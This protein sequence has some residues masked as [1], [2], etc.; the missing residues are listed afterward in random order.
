MKLI[1]KVSSEK[2][3]RAIEC[4][5][6]VPVGIMF[7]CRPVKNSKIRKETGVWLQQDEIAS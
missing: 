3:L 4:S 7:S 6:Y 5:T 2:E 1:K